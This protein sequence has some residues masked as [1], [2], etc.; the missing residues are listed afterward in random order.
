[1]RSDVKISISGRVILHVHGKLRSNVHLNL[2]I[3]FNHT[4]QI[5]SDGCCGAGH[6][7]ADQNDPRDAEGG[8]TD[9]EHGRRGASGEPAES[10]R[11]LVADYHRH[12]SRDRPPLNPLR[13]R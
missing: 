13:C 5:D 12:R 3:W 1:M 2:A 4:L 10:S 7:A 11:H 6:E 9:S 8:G